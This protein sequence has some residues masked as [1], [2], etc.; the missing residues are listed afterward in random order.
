MYSSSPKMAKWSGATC[1][2]TGLID[3]A[4]LLLNTTSTNESRFDVVIIGGALSGAATAILLLR[5]QP[6]LRVLIIEKSEKFTR[7]V[8]EATVEVSTYFLTHSLGLARH[9]NE[10]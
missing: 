7:K 9:L 1:I 10:S 3:A 4:P 6:Q 5:E 8:G 2:P